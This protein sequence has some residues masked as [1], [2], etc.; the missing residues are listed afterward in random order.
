[1]KERILKFIIFIFIILLANLAGLG[2]LPI[3]YEKIFVDY[4]LPLS[5]DRECYDEFNQPK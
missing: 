4:K 1:M 5:E 2:V 3:S